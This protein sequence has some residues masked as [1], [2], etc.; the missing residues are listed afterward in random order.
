[1]ANYYETYRTNYFGVKNNKKFLEV[2]KDADI[3]HDMCD[4]VRIQE[5]GDIFVNEKGNLE[6]LDLK[7]II[8]LII[9]EYCFRYEKVTMI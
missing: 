8:H 7:Y 2:L 1:M 5:T 4:S 3:P 6:L 9:I